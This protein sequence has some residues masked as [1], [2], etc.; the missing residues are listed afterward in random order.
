MVVHQNL[1]NSAGYF[2]FGMC[3]KYRTLSTRESGVNAFGVVKHYTMIRGKNYGVYPYELGKKKYDLKFDPSYNKEKSDRGIKNT[4]I[5]GES[6]PYI[7]ETTYDVS[8]SQA[9]MLAKNHEVFL[10]C[11]PRISPK[12]IMAYESSDYKEPKITSSIAW[13][14]DERLV[15]V[16]PIVIL[17]CDK[18]SKKV[19][20]HIMP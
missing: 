2:N 16:E 18:A 3:E 17:L 19:I 7:I 6:D 15:N 14:V 8:A 12:G 10:V 20:K 9:K 5:Y 11:K 1:T 4:D 13:N